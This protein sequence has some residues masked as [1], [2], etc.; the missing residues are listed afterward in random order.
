MSTLEDEAIRVQRAEIRDRW[1]SFWVFLFFFLL[2]NLRIAELIQCWWGSNIASTSA[3]G[4]TGWMS[5]ADILPALHLNTH[6]IRS[7]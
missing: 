1:T 5:E 4:L 6:I 2:L 3:S 7:L